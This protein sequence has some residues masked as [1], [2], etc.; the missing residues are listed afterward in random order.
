MEYPRERFELTIWL[1]VVALLPTENM[2]F[3]KEV[4]SPVFKTTKNR[5]GFNF[6][7][8]V[9]PRGCTYPKG[10]ES[11]VEYPDHFG[12]FLRRQWQ[13]DRIKSRESNGPISIRFFVHANGVRKCLTE[14]LGPVIPFCIRMWF[15]TKYISAPNGRLGG[16]R[17]S[18]VRMPHVHTKGCECDE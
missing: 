8:V 4:V 3:D 5:M 18:C 9:Q 12:I 7:L 16:S 2:A 10:L 17:E 1:K 15:K 13:L 11:A 14:V 6:S